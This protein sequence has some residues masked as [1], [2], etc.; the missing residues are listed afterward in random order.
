MP[1][2]SVLQVSKVLF[3]TLFIFL[4]TACNPFV[5]TSSLEKIQKRG[6]II[7]GT[8]NSTLTYSY[9]GNAYSGLDYELG[10][11]FAAYLN[12]KLTI[13]EYDSLN[14]LFFAIDNNKVDFVGAGLTLTPKRAKKYRSSPPYYYVSQKVVYHKG[15]YRPRNITGVNDSISVLRDS[16]HAE[17]LDA[18]IEENPNLEI[19]YFDNEDQETLLRKVA[20]K[21][22]KF[23]VVDSSTLAQKQRYY[24]AL[25]E[26]FTIS[27]KRPVAWLI[28]RNQ[29]DS[30]Y[31]GMI[32]FIGN[33]Y[34]D[35]TIA[36]LEEKYFGHV[37][38][39]DYVDTRIFLKRI[40]KTLPKYEALFKKYENS[41][42]DWK[43]LAAVS[44]QESHWNPH[45]K[46]PTGVRGMMMLTLDTADYVG[47]KNRLDP[48]QS[49]KGGAKYLSQLIKRLPATIHEEE[50]VWFALAS[51]NIGYGHLMD[52]RRITTMKKQ[53]ANSWSDVKDNL[54]LLHQR[55]W[56]KKTRYGYARGREAQHYV[57]NIRQ[58]VET[59]NWFIFEREKAQ[60]IEADKQAEIDRLAAI[61]A[62][63]H[64]AVE[65]ASKALSSEVEASK[66]IA[67]E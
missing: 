13:K 60:K 6:D 46:S 34:K 51:Y 37:A 36:L 40:K 67:T 19:N 15:T 2:K 8:I 42:V 53:N 16:S 39:F 57:N 24:P 45:A 54:P 5:Q 30:V 64:A 48:N 44:Y 61:E 58:Y 4:L 27:E 1:F 25:A 35:Q 49:V 38:H 62:A 9:D 28:K 12:V 56:Y 29:D 10:K 26:A 7:M 14:E 65:E 43:L 17:T 63:S 23:A 11:Q 33:K 21:E 52:A 50:K 32:E 55:K 47:I 66:A 20:D 31:A 3:A 59:L 41:E 22:V 18:L